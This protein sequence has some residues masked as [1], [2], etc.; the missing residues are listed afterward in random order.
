MTETFV[1][2]LAKDSILLVLT[3]AG[4]VLLM[5]LVIGS[6]VGLI[7]S[8]TQINEATL[9]FIPKMVGIIAI[10]VLLGSWM[11][12]KMMVFTVNLFNILPGLV[13]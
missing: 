13:R 2:A 12:Q 4:P 10:L 5:S 1:L 9:T 6:L 11:L 8:A 7:Q 3:L